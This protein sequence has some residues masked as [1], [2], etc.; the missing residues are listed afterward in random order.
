MKKKIC[1][2]SSDPN[3]IRSFQKTN[4]E[5]LSEKYDIYAIANFK[6]KSELGNIRIVDSFPV[7]IER[8]PSI[9]QNIKALKSLY[10]IFCDQKFDCFVSMSFN[11]SLLAAIAGK[12]AGIPNR[13]RIFT[14]QVWANMRGLKKSVFKCLDKLTVA[15]N[16][17]T[18][19]EG[20]AQYKYLIDNY[21]IKAKNTKLIPNIVGI[22]TSL[23]KP[24]PEVRIQERSKLNIPED[25]FVY[26]FLGRVNKDKG[27][28]ELFAAA[29]LLFKD[30]K[31]AK[32]VVIGPMEEGYSPNVVNK[33]PNLQ[34][35]DNIFFYGKTTEPYNALQVADAF[36]LPSYREGFGLSV[37]EASATGLPVICSD[38]YGMQSAYVENVTGIRCKMKNIESLYDCMIK[39]YKNPALSK[40]LGENGRKR[41]IEQYNKDIISGHW[42]SYL[43][44]ILK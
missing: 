39:L 29:D 14:G 18:M 1:F 31:D 15:L 12:M 4:I 5:R 2:I 17:R 19:V 41:V 26:A 38:A 42:Y 44:E 43:S 13:I 7:A 40:S 35:G 20:E 27:I 16:N 22:D 33:Y 21:V 8:R 37:L 23:F 3:G 11:A 25:A 6:D 34:I 28:N 24:N 30:I 10:R 9:S 36:C 32:L